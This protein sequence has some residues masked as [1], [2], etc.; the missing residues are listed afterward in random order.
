MA[1]AKPK[2]KKVIIDPDRDPWERQSKEPDTAWETFIT[3]R[4]MGPRRSLR[5]AMSKLGRP[6]TS[7]S[8]AENWSAIW[9]WRKRIEAWEDYQDKVHRDQIIE[10]IKKKTQQKL[11]LAD[12][13]LDAAIK[14]MFLWNRYL[15]KAMAEYNK[16]P[17]N[18][19]APP[20][21]IAD[22][23]RLA[24]ACIKISQLLAGKPTNI[25]D[26][27]ITV[28]ERRNSIRAILDHRPVRL[29]MKAVDKYEKEQRKKLLLKEA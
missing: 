11:E 20:I 21:S 6:P 7:H 17:K 28:E 23:N 3:Y 16:N 22:A 8:M 19:S 9:H 24:E 25:Q 27:R 2:Q 15:D 4:E 12:D 10:D 1:K 13:M 26:N 18:I 5:G 29:A 14:A